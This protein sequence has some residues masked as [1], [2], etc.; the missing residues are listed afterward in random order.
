MVERK[1]EIQE[2]KILNKL[3]E[4]ERSSIVPFNLLESH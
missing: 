3:L 2:K 1:T 4:R